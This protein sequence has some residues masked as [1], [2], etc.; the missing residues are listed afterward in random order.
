MLYVISKNT[1][2]PKET[3]TLLRFILNDVEL[4]K[5]LG[6]DRGIP[7]NESDPKAL[8]DNNLLERNLTI[9]IFSK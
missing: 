8:E 7:V 3:S 2:D 1:E 9:A 4:A 6:F 5:I